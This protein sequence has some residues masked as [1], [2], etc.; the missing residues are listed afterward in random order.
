M[1][2]VLCDIFSG[3]HLCLCLVSVCG[4]EKCRK[5]CVCVCVC[6]CLCVCVCVCVWVW[7]CDEG[8]S[9]VVRF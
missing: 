5:V 7:V 9:L 3:M 8:L 1:V 2:T 4:I 6:V